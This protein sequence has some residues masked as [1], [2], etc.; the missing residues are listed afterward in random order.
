MRLLWR[1]R[2]RFVKNVK[3][4]KKQKQKQSQ[5]LHEAGEYHTSFQSPNVQ[6]VMSLTEQ[7][8]EMASLLGNTEIFLKLHTDVRANELFYHSKCLKTFQCHYEAFLVKSKENNTDTAFKKAVALESTI[9]LLKQK[10]FEN[11]ECP[12]EA[13]V[14]LEIC[15]SYLTNENLLQES[16]ITDFWKMILYHTKEFEIHK[17]NHNINVFIL[18]AHYVKKTL[19]DQPF[20]CS[21]DF[22]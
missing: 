1:E 3:K 20:D 14:I 4:T 7:W 19:S 22:L 12:V 6:H 9:A 13:L 21:I 11:P 16:N 15:N 2:K 8:R 18:K 5:K 17:N 10:A